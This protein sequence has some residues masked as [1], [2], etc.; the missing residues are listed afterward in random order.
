MPSACYRDNTDALLHMFPPGGYLG[1]TRNMKATHEEFG[2]QYLQINSQV[3]NQYTLSWSV[4][5]KVVMFTSC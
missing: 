2:R 1:S 3:L 4:A 5:K